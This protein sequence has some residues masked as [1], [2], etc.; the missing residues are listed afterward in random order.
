ML[1]LG[2]KAYFHFLWSTQEYRSFFKVRQV[3][4]VLLAYQCKSVCVY[5]KVNLFSDQW[6]CPSKCNQATGAFLV[7]LEVKTQ[8]K[9]YNPLCS[10]LGEIELCRAY[11]SVN[12]DKFWLFNVLRAFYGNWANNH[13]KIKLH[14]LECLKIPRIFQMVKYRNP[15]KI[16]KIILLY[17]INHQRILQD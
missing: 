4:T 5:M 16:W 2:K 14:F 3:P 1:H 17:I 7:D 11:V 13:W 6:T 12:R 15:V 9:A 10:S 8:A